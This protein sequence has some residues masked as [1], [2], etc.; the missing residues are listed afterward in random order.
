MF[1]AESD[2]ERFFK[3]SQ[4]LAKSLAWMGWTFFIHGVVSFTVHY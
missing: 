3:I 4:H 1:T 2:N